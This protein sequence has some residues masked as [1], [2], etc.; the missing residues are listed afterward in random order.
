MFLRF[1]FR[2]LSLIFLCLGSTEDCSSV[3]GSVIACSAVCSVVCSAIGFSSTGSRQPCRRRKSFSKNLKT[4][5][6]GL[7]QK[8]FASS[9][10]NGETP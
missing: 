4:Y 9:L 7:N 3:S 5:F 6:G 2:G 10:F 8:Y 1:L